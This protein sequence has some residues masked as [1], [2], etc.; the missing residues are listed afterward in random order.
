MVHNFVF[1]PLYRQ[2]KRIAGVDI[3]NYIYYQQSKGLSDERINSITASSFSVTPF[4]DYHGTKIRVKFSGSCLKQDKIMNTHGKV[5]NIYIV[6]E[7]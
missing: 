2:F 1:Q 7:K 6:Y 3:G 4:L 5:V